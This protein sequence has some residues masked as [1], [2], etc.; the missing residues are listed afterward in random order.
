MRKIVLSDLY[1]ARLQRLELP[2][3]CL[4]LKN[5]QRGIEKEGLRV[6]S[7]A[8][9][10]QTRHPQAL[11]SA[12]MHG[13]ITT[14]YSE[15]LLELITPVFQQVDESIDYLHHLHSFT[16]RNIGDE[17]IWPASM[18]CKLDGEASIPIAQYGGSNSGQMKQVYRQGLAYRYGRMMQS[19]AGIHYNF[20]MPDS[21]WPLCQDLFENKDDIQEFK[22][23][24][25][26]SL[27]RNFQ[28]YSWLL[29]YL[30]GA[31]PALDS[32]F[33]ENNPHEL[34]QLSK[35]TLGLPFATSL[36]MSDLGYKSSAQGNLNICYRGVDS[37]IGSLSQAIQ[38]NYPDYESIGVKVD[39][40]YRQLNTNLL[41]IENEHY[42]NIRPKRVTSSGEAPLEAL[43]KRGVE[44]VEVRTLD[45]NP[46][47]AVG[48]DAEQVRF[49]DAFL[50]YCLLA[51]SDDIST[52]EN[53]EINYNQQR[54]IL[55][56]RRPSL[57]LYRSGNLLPFKDAANQLL[58]DVENVAKLLDIAHEKQRLDVQ[59]YRH[60]VMLQ[61]CKV[62]NSERTP[63]GQIMHEILSGKDFHQMTQMQAETYKRQF[64][65]QAMPPGFNM[66]YQRLAID[67]VRRQQQLENNETSCFDDFLQAYQA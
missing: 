8:M 2:E 65:Q 9:L 16:L 47:M 27:I 44:Y 36:R 32:S 12:L 61:R 45:I 3:N 35:S 43:K 38:E 31:S 67:S 6:T 19:I 62:E 37:Y 54:C 40:K 33:M 42:S 55:E 25:Y 7:Q 51:D 15:A 1:R 21:F 26:F 39:G 52:T 30:F 57:M 64:L 59:G 5:I 18:P 13:S 14:D 22:S 24:C 29:S 23:D 56:G 28:R 17:Y 4:L 50:L 41:Q 49:L 66:E 46:F 10:A 58:D 53:N 11:G 34:V 48:I 63:S 20:S 60:S